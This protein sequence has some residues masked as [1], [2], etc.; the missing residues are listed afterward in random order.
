MRELRFLAMAIA[1]PGP[2]RP[3]LDGLPPAAFQNEGHRRAFE[4]I[5]DGAARPRRLAGRSRAASVS[6]CGSSCARSAP[7]A[8]EV[9]E[10]AY[11]VEL[12]ML[13][14]RAAEMRSRGDEKGRLEAL[15]L[16][17]RVRAALRADT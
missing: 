10:A 12:P 17:R 4:L 2:A 14:R 6:P 9:R 1:A 15:D 3:Y 13:E 7:T 11:R 8:A 16:A 5:R